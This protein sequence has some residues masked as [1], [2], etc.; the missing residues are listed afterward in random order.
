MGLEHLHLGISKKDE[1]RR[2]QLLEA[3]RRRVKL[4]KVVLVGWLWLVN[5]KGSTSVKG[6]REFKL[7]GIIKEWDFRNL[8]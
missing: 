8:A 3:R 6:G 1:N 4:F 5:E 2:W 7:K